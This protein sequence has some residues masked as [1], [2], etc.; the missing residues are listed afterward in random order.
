[1]N[2][3]GRAVTA[4]VI[5]VMATASFAQVQQPEKMSFWQ[6]RRVILASGNYMW[7]PGSAVVPQA[8]EECSK[9]TSATAKTS[10][11][12]ATTQAWTVNWRRLGTA[13]L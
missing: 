7:V 8:I 4:F 12:F 2:R 9:I 13:E 3:F 1:M 11:S 6:A 10:P 5:A